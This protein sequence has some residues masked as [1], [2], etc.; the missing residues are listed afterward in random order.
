MRLILTVFVVI[1]AS[2]AVAEPV[3]DGPVVGGS[4]GMGGSDYY[5]DVRNRMPY[6]GEMAPQP[7]GVAGI[8]RARASRRRVL[9]APRRSTIHRTAASPRS[10][11]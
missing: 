6:T 4:F 1:T 2:A 10:P 9:V 11:D 5:G 7:L 8:E 3:L